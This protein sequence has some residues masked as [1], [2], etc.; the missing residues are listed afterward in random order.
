MDLLIS[1][2]RDQATSESAPLWE[3]SNSES[4]SKEVNGSNSIIHAS[5]THDETKKKKSKASQ[6]Q[7]LYKNIQKQK[8]EQD[9]GERMQK[10]KYILGR[11]K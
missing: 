10:R 7:M 2:F 5:V 4:K 1:E 8:K 3:A 6:L 11:F 9:K